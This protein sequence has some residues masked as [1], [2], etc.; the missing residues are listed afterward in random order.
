[1]AGVAHLINGHEQAYRGLTA[2]FHLLRIFS[3]AIFVSPLV[4]FI[5]DLVLITL[6]VI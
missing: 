4:C 2:V 5:V 6:F 3:V 1:M